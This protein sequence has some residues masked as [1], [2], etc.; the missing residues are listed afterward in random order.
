MI[1][2]FITVI[3]LAISL[4]SSLGQ[5][6]GWY[7]FLQGT[8]DK[9]PVS[10]H[11]HKWANQ[12]A[13]YYYYHNR[14]EPLYF[15]GDDTTRAGFVRLFVYLPDRE[16]EETFEFKLE[17]DAATGEWRTAGNAKALSFH[18]VAVKDTGL[19]QYNF[20]FAKSSAKL[21]PSLQDSP[22]ASY[23]AASVWPAGNASK[24]NFIK[25]VISTAW[26]EKTVQQDIGKTLEKN[27]KEF[28][29]VYVR[30]NK[31][32]TDT[33][34]K[35]MGFSLNMSEESRLMIVYQSRKIL[36]T[37]LYTYTYSGG[38]HGIFGTTYSGYD[39]T[40]NKKLSLADI[41]TAAGK[42]KLAGSLEKYFRKAYKLKPAD[43]LTEI[44]FENKIAPNDNFYV[45]EKGIGFCYVPYEIASYAMG[46][47]NI[48]IPFT[49][50]NSYLQ[51]GFKKLIQ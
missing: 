41:I 2:S 48:F 44:L 4:N 50:L 33:E 40:L 8:I 27:R 39:L 23:E 28:V 45:T 6:S 51:P 21:R 12:Y 13:G 34:I 14:Q 9:Y 46:E 24:I 43:P 32:M 22:E 37:A 42:T 35:E 38:A 10:L 11:L 25:K 1:R 5:G 7:K 47:I 26:G 49:E 17:N 15:T 36:T 31:G 30:E 20:V 18:A 19:P 29:D 16:S 3:F